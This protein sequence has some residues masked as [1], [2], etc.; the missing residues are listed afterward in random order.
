MAEKNDPDIDF[1]QLIAEERA[2]G[3]RRPVKA[4][5]LELRRRRRKIAQMLL[6]KRCEKR[7]YLSVLRDD[8]GLKE[9]SPEFHEFV[10]LWD[11]YR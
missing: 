6:D 8:F 1:R 7:D 3:S 11:A 9:E 5:T 10:K 2:R 4:E